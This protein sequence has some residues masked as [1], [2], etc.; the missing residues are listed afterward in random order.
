MR[1]SRLLYNLKKMKD[2]IKN[3]NSLPEALATI[4]KTGSEA[5]IALARKNYWRVYKAN[6][7]K[8]K[9]IEQ[10]EFT[11]SF[12]AK[13]LRVISTAAE[14]HQRSR[15]KFIK[16]AAL[17]YCTRRFVTTDPL[18]VNQV[19]ELLALNYNAMQQQWE[20]KSFLFEQDNH[21]PLSQMAALEKSV[22]EALQSPRS[23][24][25][26]ILEA[27]NNDPE[28]RISIMQLLNTIPI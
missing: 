27:I 10:K 11:I 17:A 9:R 13:E 4:L 25:T 3:K 28:Y 7:R 26:L 5:E 2:E 8:Q 23:L 20:K 19:R 16:E 1:T 21:S 12:N 15:T 18:A 6:W 24:D 14:K 22:M